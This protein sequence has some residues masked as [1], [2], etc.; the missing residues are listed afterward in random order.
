M[1][2][3][4]K[5][6]QELLPEHH[7]IHPADRHKYRWELVD[8]ESFIFHLDDPTAFLNWSKGKYPA[9]KNNLFAAPY[10]DFRDI[11]RFLYK[12]WAV[13]VIGEKKRLL[14]RLGGEVDLSTPNPLSI[15]QG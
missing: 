3:F 1:H 5:F 8:A 14:Y 10:S 12:E 11:E 7:L 15:L 6:G 2:P 4:L 13:I 9:H